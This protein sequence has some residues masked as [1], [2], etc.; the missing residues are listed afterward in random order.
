MSQFRRIKK[1]PKLVLWILAM[2]LRV[3]R[4]TLRVRIEDGAGI[5]AGRCDG[6]PAILVIWHNRLPLLPAVA[7][8]PIRQ[9]ITFLASRSRDGGY[10]SDLLALFGMSAVRGSS[11]KGG[12]RATRELKLSIEAQRL[13]AVTPDGP[14]GPRYT[15]H[16]GVLWLARQTGAP[17]IPVALNARHH[18]ELRSWDRTQL[19]LPLTGVELVIGEP[20]RVGDTD[21][22]D[23]ALRAR[24]QAACLAITRYD[25]PPLP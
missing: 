25:H 24:F 21:P 17:L 5:L 23:D 22:I 8:A 18:W 4:L 16:D 10:I 15:V 11:S 20:F 13:V 2:A 7:P 3:W 12:V 9:R 19:P 1:F 14:R 6:Q